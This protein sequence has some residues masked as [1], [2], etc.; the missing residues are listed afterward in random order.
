[1]PAAYQTP[2]V[3]VEWLDRSAQQL[4]V[5]R[6]DVAGFVGLA[7]RGP[8]HL[9][10]KIE[11]DQ[12]FFSTFGGPIADGYLAYA[13]TGFFENGGRT[14]WVVRAADTTGARPASL[15]LTVPGR[16]APIGIVATSDGA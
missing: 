3:Y 9:A 6:T 14:C 16:P 13:A 1:M 15:L 7:E 8:L 12:Q 5:G 4:V 10:V 11:S 2:G